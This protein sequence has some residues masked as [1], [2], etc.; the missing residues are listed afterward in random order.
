MQHLNITNMHS[1]HVALLL[2]K[3]C[4]ALLVVAYIVSNAN[5]HCVVDA[6]IPHAASVV[7][8]IHMRAGM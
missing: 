1:L 2:S 4:Y 3:S 6:D 5:R 8:T 7:Y